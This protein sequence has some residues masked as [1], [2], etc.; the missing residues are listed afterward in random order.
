MISVEAMNE[1]RM[2]EVCEACEARHAGK[3][4][5]SR[6]S[7]ER[8]KNGRRIRDCIYCGCGVPEDLW[9][10]YDPKSESMQ[11]NGTPCSMAGSG[12]A[13][14]EPV[15]CTKCGEEAVWTDIDPD[16]DIDPVT[17]E[18]VPMKG[19]SRCRACGHTG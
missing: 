2:I 17:D 19:S 12:G 5:V 4:I 9:V 15:K 1:I 13:R 6:Y 14:R 16:Y 3:H 10:E 11:C 8:E 7:P 18:L